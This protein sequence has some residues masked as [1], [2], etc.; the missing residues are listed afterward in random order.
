MKRTQNMVSRCCIYTLFL[1]LIPEIMTITQIRKRDGELIDFDRTRIEVAIDAAANDAG[2]ADRTFV[3][4]LT[5]FVVKDLEHVYGEIFVNRVPGVEDI[6]DI[7]EQNLMKFHKYEVAKQFIIYRAKRSDERTEK[8]EELVKQFEENAMKVTKSDGSKAYFDADKIRAVFDRAVKGYEDRCTFEDLMEAFKKNLVEDIKTSDINKMLVKTCID[9]VSVENINWEHIAGRI[10]LGNLYKQACKNRGIK[11]KDIYTAASYKD[12]FDDYVKKDL[13]YKDFYKYYSEADILAA[14]KKIRAEIDMEY[15]YTTVLSLHKRYLLN[16]NKVIKELPQEMYM[17]I[18]LFLA[19]PEK[20]EDRLAFALQAYEQLANQKISLATPS[21]M[22]SRTNYHQL[23]SCFKLN[24]DD[25]LRSIYHNVENIAQISKFGGG[26]GA[27]MGNIR[28]RGSAIRDVKNLS[29][30]VIPWLKVINDTAVAVNQ[31]GS[32]MGAVSVTLDIWHKDIYDFLDLQSETG[33]IRS[34]A[35]DIFPAV[36]IPDIF[37]RRVQEDRD[38]TLFDPHEIESVYGRRIQDCYGE[39]FEAFYTELEAS[40]KLEVR[41]TGKA[42]DLFKKFLKTTVETGMPYVFF[43]DTVNAVNPN[44]HAGQVYAT[45]L[46]TEICQNTSP[47]KFLEET[48]EDGTI[49]I[50]YQAGDTVTCNLASINLAKVRDAKTMSETIPVAM[51]LLDNVITLNHYPLE[52]ARQTAMRYRPVGLGFLGLAELLAT[53]G[54]AYE[55][56]EARAYVNDLFE[57][58]SLQIYRTSAEI[59]RDRGAYQL[60]PGS[61]YD[62]GYI[63]GKDIATRKSESKYAA[64]WTEIYALMAA[65]GLRFGYH[66]APAPNTSTAGVVGTTA[67]LL[68]IYKKYF[69]E[70]N[71]TAPT[72]RIAPKLSPENFWLYKEYINMDM[73]DVIDMIATVYQWI[74]QSISFEWMIDPAKVSPAQ[75]YGYYV[76]AWE[77]KIKTVYYV[78]SLSGEVKE[79]CVSCSG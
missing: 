38:W 8:K 29:G 51:R 10:F 54:Y 31:L 36:T 61:E 14:G 46:C 37:M 59:A 17:S 77:Q 3:H 75:L 1:S 12:L 30:G 32:R 7:V 22:N 25:D 16:P 47:S 6:Q 55:S 20:A 66:T 28:A 49:S 50:K 34:K 44:K 69:V 60:F 2:E 18:A 71:I 63:L 79:G 76:K 64:E 42:K 45:Q 15:G 43:R 41:S 52:E 58:F 53:S 57:Q 26:V 11:V 35:F 68:P 24:V 21:L 48:L 72:I 74:D 78:R 5:D 4:V 33:D 62:R 70:T 27:Y 19:I 65:H 39:K 13:Y 23:S 9:L 56:A 73:N 67:G 40:D